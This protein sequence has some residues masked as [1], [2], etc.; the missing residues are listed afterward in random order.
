MTNAIVDLSNM[1]FRSMFIVG[2][3]GKK[4]Y[5]FDSQNEVDQLMR[6]VATD[7]S[8]VIRD[9]NPSRVIF[10]LDSRSWR[11]D[12]PID[13]NEGYK[14]HRKKS[15]N[16]NWDNIYKTMDD[17][18]EILKTNGFI[19]SKIENAEADDIISL[20]KN[21]IVMNRNEHAILVSADEDVRQLVDDFIYFPDLNSSG[22]HAFSVVYNPFTMG[23]NATKKLFY[24]GDF[25][26]WLNDEDDMGDIFNRSIDVDKEDF[27]RILTVDKVKAEFVDGPEIAMRKIFCGVDGDNV[28]AIFSWINEKGK[29]IRITPV[30]YRKI[31]DYIGA[32]TYLDLFDE[33]KI[34]S[35]F[36]QIVEI[37]GQRPSFKMKDRLKRQAKLVVLDQDLFP[38]EIVEKFYEDV[39]E[40]FKKPQIRPQSW[41]MLSMLEGTRYVDVGKQSDGAESPI[42]NQVDRISNKELF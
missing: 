37:S 6:K 18:S 30:K 38:E 23:R 14:G 26:L 25:L 8:S 11:K 1:F 29:E 32:E 39:K 22:K 2:G 12:I 9:I 19:V 21:E 16:I 40:E 10:A 5:T 4:Q 28:P 34:D 17:F 36:D 35:V 42:F 41:N 20:W 24:P 7:I 13:E 33:S 3:F 27:Q 15:K 31:I